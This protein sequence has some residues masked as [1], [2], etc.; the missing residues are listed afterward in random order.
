VP[1]VLL[2]TG[3]LRHPRHAHRHAGT[4]E[5]ARRLD[6]H[7]YNR[8]SAPSPAPAPRSALWPLQLVPLPRRTP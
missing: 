6:A 1:F 7:G 3:K 4:R 5:S 2:K 8:P